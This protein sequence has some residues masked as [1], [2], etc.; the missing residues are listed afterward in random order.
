MNNFL[1]LEKY[2]EVLDIAPVCTVDVLFFNENKTETLLF[3]RKNEPIKG[4][5]FSVGGRL[6]KNEHLVDCAI[7]QASQ[8]VG[9]NVN[10]D[11]LTFGGVQEELN[12]NSMFDDVSY[13][14]I[15]VFYGYVL[16]NEEIKLDSQHCDYKWFSVSDDSLHPFIKTKIA[17][18]LKAYEQKL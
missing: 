11:K 4:L 12:P 6:F 17:S 14:A 1:P 2:R 15:D 16:D 9:V 10:S 7:R 5:Y 13:H 18:L 8:E 3:K